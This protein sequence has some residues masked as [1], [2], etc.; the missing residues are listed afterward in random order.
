MPSSNLLL[1]LTTDLVPAP[2]QILCPALT[3][4]P[5]PHPDRSSPIRDT[6]SPALPYG[7]ESQVGAGASPARARWLKGVLAPTGAWENV[8]CAVSKSL[9]LPPGSVS[10]V[11]LLLFFS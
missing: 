7:R 4:T 11:L 10:S 8:C 1:A 6:V 3:P 2:T 5:S 9:P